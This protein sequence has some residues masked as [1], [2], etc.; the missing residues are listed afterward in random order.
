MYIYYIKNSVAFN[1]IISS[2]TF[3]MLFIIR[4][5]YIPVYALVGRISHNE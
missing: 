3:V 4:C 1:C 2:V 5:M